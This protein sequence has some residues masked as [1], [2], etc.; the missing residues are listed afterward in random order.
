MDY[1]TVSF[2]HR[3]DGHHAGS[4]IADRRLCQFLAIGERM[5]GIASKIISIEIGKAHWSER[6]ALP[7]VRFGVEKGDVGMRSVFCNRAVSPSIHREM[8]EWLDVGS[9]AHEM[10]TF[11]RGMGLS[12]KS[13]RS[14]LGNFEITDG[15]G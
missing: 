13:D 14:L 3:F 9:I 7:C 8:H 12:D 5:E 11:V 2:L 6:C 1:Q 4:I 10:I 15:V